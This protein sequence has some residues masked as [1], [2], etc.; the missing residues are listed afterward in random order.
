M[1][2]VVRVFIMYLHT[3]MQYIPVSLSYDSVNQDNINAIQ[4]WTAPLGIWEGIQ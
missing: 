1:K 2:H 3:A 4:P